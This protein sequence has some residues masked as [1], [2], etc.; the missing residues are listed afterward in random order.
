MPGYD[1]GDTVRLSVVDRFL[2]RQGDSAHTTF[3]KRVI[4]TSCVAIAALYIFNLVNALS[5]GPDS[6]QQAYLVSVPGLTG[7]LVC[8]TQLLIEK[9]LRP[10]VIECL[11]YGVSI[12]VLLAD[13][14]TASTS[15]ERYWPGF[16][17]ILDV[18]L[19]CRLDTRVSRCLLLLVLTWC[20]L[21]SFEA[22]FRVGILDSPLLPSQAYRRGRVTCSRLPCPASAQYVSIDWIC[23]VAV[24]ILDY[25]FTRKFAWAHYE[26]HDKMNA[27][28]VTTENIASSLSRFDLEA[29]AIVIQE[30]NLPK[31]LL[32]SLSHVLENLTMYRRYLPQSVLLGEEFHDETATV[33]N[34]L[35]AK[36]YGMSQGFHGSGSIVSRASHISLK[37]AADKKRC[38]FMV[39]NLVGSHKSVLEDVT[40]FQLRYS[41]YMS[42][43]LNAT[44]KHMGAVGVV[45]GD[46]IH[47]SFNAAKRCASHAKAAVE[48][49]LSVHSNAKLKG[50]RANCGITTGAAY[51]GSYGCADM[52]SFSMIGAAAVL[53]SHVERFGRSKKYDIVTCSAVYAEVSYT[54]SMRVIL[55]RLALRANDSQEIVYEVIPTVPLPS[56]SVAPEEWMYEI[57][58]NHWDRFNKAGR[59]YLLGNGAEAMR[60]L[61]IPPLNKLPPLVEECERDLK[62]RISLE[63]GST[64]LVII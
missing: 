6:A 41:Q 7:S 46:H 8:L 18:C 33:A 9:K 48:T 59:H 53:A 20:T 54:F 30:S 38:S 60:L 49:A 16:I 1:E 55:S 56:D 27:T 34:H 10:L 23:Q 50:I 4:S 24:V 40:G 31:P 35:L 12:S 36:E 11:L 63:E 39:T 57:Q 47:A 19:L 25:Y 22:Y 2:R 37:D 26:E 14:I 29:A 45:V 52:M 28:I 51:C 3:C 44:L 15:G 17:I 21:L 5:M 61:H 13:Q 43:V 62:E 42:E 64:S 58:E 32:Q